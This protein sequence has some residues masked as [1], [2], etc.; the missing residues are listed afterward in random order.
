ME[1]LRISNQ[2][3]ITAM[4]WF[5]F[6]LLLTQAGWVSSCIFD[7]VGRL[8]GV[9]FEK[10]VVN[11]INECFAACYEDVRC[12]GIQY[13]K[14]QKDCL[15]LRAGNGLHYTVDDGRAIAYSLLRDDV[16]QTCQTFVNV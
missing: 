12:T 9:T 10:F 1:R 15:L 2:S 13:W 3:A 5:A 16:D 11:N 6:L 4:K 8:E 7:K 14:N